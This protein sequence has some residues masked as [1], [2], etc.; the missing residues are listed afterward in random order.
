MQLDWGKY[1]TVAD[2]FQRKA[3]SQDREDLRHDIIL[4]LAE[5]AQRNGDKPLT[6]VSMIRVA[7]Y[8]VM[9]YWHSVNRGSVKVCV[10]SG[11]ATKPFYARC[12]WEHKPF[13][14][15]ECT[16]LAV[17]PVGSLNQELDD[18]EGN[19]QALI[20]T[21]AD[22]DAIDLDAWLDAR[23]WLLGCPKRLVEVVYKRASGLP[24]K[25]KD[26]VYLSQY[27]KQAQKSLL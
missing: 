6:T 19:T 11:V 5:V 22:D 12:K 14:C 10:F 8:V 4:R 24:L 20:D 27:H 21:L 25:A 9:E 16:Y 15:R 17:R 23:R 26:R 13:S 2:R 1:I 18:G 7:S 3:T